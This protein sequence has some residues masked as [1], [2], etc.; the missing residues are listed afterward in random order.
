[1]PGLSANGSTMSLNCW[2]CGRKL[3]ADAEKCPR[4]GSPL[5]RFP[6]S[7]DG[8]AM[9]EKISRPRAASKRRP[10]PQIIEHATG[11]ARPGMDVAGMFRGIFSGGRAGLSATVAASRTVARSVALGSR[12][13]ATA[14]DAARATGRTA[15]NAVG[16]VGRGGA[17]LAKRS[18]PRIDVDAF[19]RENARTL[20]DVAE[21]LLR[22]TR[23]ENARLRARIEALEAARPG[24]RRR[25]ASDTPA[26]RRKPRA[27][28]AAIEP[29]PPI[30]TQPEAAAPVLA[31]T[32]AG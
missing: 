2:N 15:A 5:R 26:P 12:K 18:P 3:T 22:E 29:S 8:A 32:T 19:H 7:F 31:E 4:C 11:P 13:A 27:K 28:P 16:S 9:A 23:E 10:Q 20:V 21:L 14:A 17:T 30:Q 1:M 24:Q 6:D 25:S